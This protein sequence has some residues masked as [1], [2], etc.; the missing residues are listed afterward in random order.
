MEGQSRRTRRGWQWNASVLVAVAS[1]AVA[2]VY[3]AMQARDSARQIEISQ[4]SLQLSADANQLANLLDLQEEI[5][6]ADRRTSAAFLALTEPGNQRRKTDALV[7]AVTPLEGIAYALR[8]G[9]IKIPEARALWRRYLVCAFYTARQGIGPTL[10][11]YVPELAQ[12]AR[13]ERTALGPDRQCVQV[14]I[15]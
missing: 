12:F 9:I 5:T 1:V 15:P 11:S 7:Q 3:S 4:R 14:V 2:L 13:S 8:R 6:D 10:D